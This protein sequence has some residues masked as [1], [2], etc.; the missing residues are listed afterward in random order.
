LNNAVNICRLKIY[1]DINLSHSQQNN[2]VSC[3]PSSNRKK[4]GD[5]GKFVS[6][7]FVYCMY[8]I[9]NPFY[10]DSELCIPDNQ[11]SDDLGELDACDCLKESIICDGSAT[12]IIKF[13]ECIT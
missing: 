1:H 10:I 4:P 3:T 2:Y 8:Y 11:L 12:V 7:F 13:V 5:N 9:R 6:S